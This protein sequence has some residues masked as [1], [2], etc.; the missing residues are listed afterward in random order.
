MQTIKEAANEE[1]TI[2][3]Y[4]IKLKMSNVQLKLEFKND[5]RH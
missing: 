2:I 4:K 3:G 1:Y 5:Y